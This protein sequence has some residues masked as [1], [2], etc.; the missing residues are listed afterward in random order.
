MRGTIP[1]ILQYAFIAWCS[2]KA[3]GQLYFSFTY[4]RLNV[5]VLHQYKPKRKII[6]LYILISKF[7]ESR[8][9]YSQLNGS[10]Q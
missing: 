2:V 7:L 6:V 8:Q 9:E 4:D 3:Q 10:K 5:Q 1:P